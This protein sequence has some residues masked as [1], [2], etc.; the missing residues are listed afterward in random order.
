M[1]IRK[2]AL[3]M[4]ALFVGGLLFFG[5]SKP[6]HAALT[7]GTFKYPYC[8]AAATQYAGGFNPGVGYGGF[9]G[10]TCTA[11]K[12]PVVFVH[13]NTDSALGWDSPANTAP[14][15]YPVQNQS[16]Y[17]YF[18]SKGYN[19]CELF[20]V[21]YL[22][23][24]E[25]GH[26]VLNYHQESK[27]AIIKTFIDKVKAYTGKTQV[28]IVSHSLGSSMS[29]ATLK[30]YGTWSSVRRFVNIAGGIRGLNSCLYTGYANPYVPTC[31]SENLFDSYV[32]GFYPDT[33]V[34]G[35]GN[36]RWT[37]SSSSG[38]R[39]LPASATAV[40]FYTIGAGQQ[41][42]IHCS[43]A[44][45]WSTCGVGPTFTARSNVISQINVGAGSTAIQY[46]YDLSDGY[47]TNF[48]GGD[49]NG[50][51]HFKARNNTSTIIYDM[52][53]T[54]CSGIGCASNYIYGPKA[55]Y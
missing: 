20:G 39:N 17:A 53:N 44:S 41:D 23:T 35:Y 37:G 45:G 13:G 24:S 28:D 50:V 4:G 1:I 40:R 15:G 2:L 55:S 33:G 54:T 31:G 46:D 16:I 51:G 18:K 42:Q 14:A 43:T 49:T 36:N 30:Y 11:T 22:D 26:D 10:G 7:C 8:Q 48:N 34:Y 6:A 12:T 29:L 25:Q 27:Y 38:M 5:G 52:L 32:F 19:D 3:A 47:Y 9:G 21:T